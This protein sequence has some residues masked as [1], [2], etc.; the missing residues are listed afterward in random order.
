MKLSEAITKYGDV[1]IA[2]CLFTKHF[3]YETT[4]SLKQEL[5]KI[6]MSRCVESGILCSFG[7]QGHIM[8]LK[9]I[10][11]GGF[12]A[13]KDGAKYYECKPLMDYIYAC[14]NGLDERPLP[15]GFQ[16]R[17]YYISS[18]YACSK[19]YYDYD[20]GFDWKMVTAFEVIRV[21]D[22]YEL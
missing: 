2:E 20:D 22:G 16:I 11:E 17:G 3:S 12:Q 14:P 5:K 1:D 19:I 13:E 4:E 15:N 9:V 10:S 8:P 18:G 21:G 6:D 7:P